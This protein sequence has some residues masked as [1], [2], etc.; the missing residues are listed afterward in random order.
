MA[1]DI[2]RFLGISRVIPVVV[3]DDAAHAVPLADALVAGGIGIAEITL[4]TPAALAG[5]ERLARERPGFCVAGGTCRSADDLRRVADAGAAF[6]V[7][8]GSTP[9]LVRAARGL[10]LPWL[11]G[12]ATPS[13]M[14]SLADEG[15]ACLKFFPAMQAGGIELLKAVAPVL[16]AVRFCPTGGITAD[17][18]AACLALSNVLCVGGSWITPADLVRRGAWSDITRIAAATRDQ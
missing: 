7:S 5:I 18:A 14:M 12:A 15:H 9:S 6:A 4:R 2:A 17:N 10:T 3:L 13:E 1:E 8:P 11:P 16:P